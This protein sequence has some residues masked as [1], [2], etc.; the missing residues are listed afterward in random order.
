MRIGKLDGARRQ[1]HTAITLYFAEGDPVSIHS[2]AAAAY[3]LLDDLIAKHGA[4]PHGF[5]DLLLKLVK[6]EDVTIVR[7]KLNEAQNFF[8]HADRDRDGSLDFRP[9]TTELLLVEA[10]ER[11]FALTGEGVPTFD[12]FRAWF[13]LGGFGTQFVLP[14]ELEKAR[15]LARGAFGCTSRHSFF[16]EVL[17]MVAMAR[18]G[19]VPPG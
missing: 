13:M 12:V 11:Y 6:P 17:P 7:Q 9:E 3:Q 5:K 16:V 15:L 2:L 19:G 14:A 1:L 4:G 8:K 10:C 18:A